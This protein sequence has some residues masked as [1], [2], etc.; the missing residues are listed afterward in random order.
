MKVRVRRRFNRWERLKETLLE[1]MLRRQPMRSGYAKPMVSI[2]GDYIS[3]RIRTEGLYEREILEFLRNCVFDLAACREQIALD[4]G[5]N[6]GNHSIYLA[7]IFKQVIAFEPNPLTRSMLD[8][9]LTLNHVANVDVRSVALSST[10]G[11]EMLHFTLRN[12]GEAHLASIDAEG[13]EQG[14]EVEL[15]AGD[16]VIDEAD[17]IGFVKVDVEGAELSVLEGLNGILRNHQPLVAIEQWPA[18]IDE[19]SGSSPS[20]SF[21][22]NLGYTAWE[23]QTRTGVGGRLG[24]IASIFFG[25]ADIELVAV[26][27][28]ERRQYPAL[29]FTP[30]EYSFPAKS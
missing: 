18:G 30:A 16:D 24:K 13:N 2:I 25:S 15:A 21:L 7:D 1:Q 8:I 28:L 22:Q 27:R 12:L 19:S 23:I 29:L 20:F 10:S 14:I 9:N 17:R 5:A 4:V 6:I 3:D 11:K 26:D